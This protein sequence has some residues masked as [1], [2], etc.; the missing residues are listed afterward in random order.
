M[1]ECASTLTRRGLSSTSGA[2]G[3]S[4]HLQRSDL[5]VTSSVLTA[6]TRS[7]TPTTQSTCPRP[8]RT[9]RERAPLRRL[10]NF[11]MLATSSCWRVAR[12]TKPSTTTTTRTSTAMGGRGR[13]PT[14]CR[15]V[16]YSCLP[17]CGCAPKESADKL[18]LGERALVATLAPIIRASSRRTALTESMKAGPP[19]R[20]AAAW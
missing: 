19:W 14:G 2:T 5:P 7:P 1:P 3:P 20:T 16:R 8:S 4:R 10:A 11:I 18:V 13:P 9:I 17:L 6:G 12:C 15:L